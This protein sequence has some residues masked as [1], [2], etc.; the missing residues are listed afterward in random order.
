[1]AYPCYFFD[2]QPFLTCKKNYTNDICF[3]G[4]EARLHR[5]NNVTHIFKI[6]YSYSSF[7]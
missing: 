6:R 4:F 1:M 3:H 5:Y 2:E 7:F